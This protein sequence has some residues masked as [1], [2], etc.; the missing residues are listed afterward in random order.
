M[1]VLVGESASG[2]STIQNELVDYFGYEKIVT[3]TTRPQ[4]KGEENGK[5]YY[6]VSD[7]EFNSLKNMNYFFF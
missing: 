2:K 6:F 5:D 3:F 1:I 7:S 4:R